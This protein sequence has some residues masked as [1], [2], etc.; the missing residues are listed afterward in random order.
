[1]LSPDGGPFLL[2]QHIWN[3]IDVFEPSNSGVVYGLL[4]HNISDYNTY[5]SFFLF[6]FFLIFFRA[7]VTPV[8]FPFLVL[9]WGSGIRIKA[10][11][12]ARV[13]RPGIS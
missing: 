7:G 10:Q 3:I 1:M 11:A 6:F 4:T 12:A 5:P 8:R 13:G 9:R 2:I